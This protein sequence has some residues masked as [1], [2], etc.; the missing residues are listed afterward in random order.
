[1]SQN[2]PTKSFWKRPEG[3]T[4]TL[5]LVAAIGGALFFGAPVLAAI[6]AGVASLLQMVVTGVILAAL[7]FLVID[8]RSRNLVGYGYKSIMRWLTGWF[9]QLDPIAILRSYLDDMKKNLR[10]MNK[11]IGALRGQMR[12]LRN[13]M[14][15]NQRDIQNNMRQ[16][17]KAKK[18]G[19]ESQTVLKVR[20]A[21][22][23]K[24][25]NEKLDSLYKRMEV[26]YRVLT[27]MY[28]N[29]E[30]LY[31]DTKDQIKIKEQ[32]RKAIR[33]S[34]SAM[35][36]AMSIINGNNDKRAMFDQ[37]MEVLA[38]DVANKV[39]E[40]ERFMDVSKGFMDSIDLQNGVFE[41]Q[42]MQMLEKWEKESTS[43][44]LGDDKMNLLNE[45]T[46]NTTIDLNIETP[47]RN[48]VPR[49]KG[50]DNEYSNL[51]D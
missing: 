50:N 49:S 14:D 51:F 31:E 27:K 35:N 42:G 11:Q 3:V 32:E 43:L 13:T 37:A 10:N 19:N 9:I 1:M 8:K 6:A 16:A 47:V 33:A 7:L 15:Q 44:L 26:M 30:I 41:E 17:Q 34:H 45:G 12:S 20:K 38:D 2:N 22:R 24:D 25:S 29:S 18:E 36:S 46:T 23:L 21:S 48:K 28:Q 5:F 4:G 39:G 40:M